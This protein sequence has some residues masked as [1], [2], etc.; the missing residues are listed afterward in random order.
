[1][2]VA[3]LKTMLVFSRMRRV[4]SIRQHEDVFWKTAVKLSINVFIHAGET[5]Y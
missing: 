1:M 4:R 5:S 3:N 2:N